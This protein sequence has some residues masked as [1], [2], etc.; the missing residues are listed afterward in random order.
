MR[1]LAA[2]LLLVAGCAHPS[3]GLH[4]ETNTTT[5]PRLTG[6]ELGEFERAFAASKAERR[7]VA[8]LSP[9]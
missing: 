9:S 5:A 3:S 1:A 4:A 7:L 2:L 6:F 8:L